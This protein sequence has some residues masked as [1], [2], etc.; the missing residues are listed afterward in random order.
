MKTFA[1]HFEQFHRH[2]S[3]KNASPQEYCHRVVE[4]LPKQFFFDAEF[5]TKGNSF[6]SLLF[7]S[8]LKKES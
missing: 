7:Y 2:K 6:V 8:S 3:A 1:S 5:L 4:G